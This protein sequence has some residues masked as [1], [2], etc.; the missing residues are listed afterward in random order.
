M[1]I[2]VHVLTGRNL[3]WL[4]IIIRRVEGGA[5]PATFWDNTTPLLLLANA[6]SKINVQPRAYKQGR[7]HA[8]R[9]HGKIQN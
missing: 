6:S 7:G 9:V 3:I 8:L 4:F 1:A 5:Q 2:S